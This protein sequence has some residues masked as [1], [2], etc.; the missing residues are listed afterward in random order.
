[1]LGNLVR[2][3]NGMEERSLLMDKTHILSLG[4]FGYNRSQVDTLLNERNSKINEL[5]TQVETL[6]KELSEAK[7]A[8]VH[9]EELE[10]ALT[11]GILDARIKGQEIVDN[12]QM[13]AKQLIDN[14]NEQVVQYKEEFVHHS[15]ELVTSG[16][17]LRS[18]LNDMKSKMQVII[19]QYQTLLDET[20]FD[21]LFPKKQVD[22]LILQV[23]DY[24]TDEL[25]EFTEQPLPQEPQLSE[26]EKSELSRLISE[27]LGNEISDNEK[28]N[29][30][31]PERKGNLVDFTTL[32]RK[33][34]E[35]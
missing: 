1:M 4:L 27:V 33:N 7:E 3:N 24:E 13:E 19:D 6:T 15:R 29:T 16:S 26:D 12:S 18:E 35:Q 20:D 32:A 30:K 14:T 8:L 17:S 10:Q 34:N 25:N 31:K 5:E 9:F 2:C 23:E 28:N 21:S 11:D 22:R